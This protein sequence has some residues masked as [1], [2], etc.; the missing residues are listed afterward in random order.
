METGSYKPR[1]VPVDILRLL[2]QIRGETREMVASKN[3]DIEISL[4]DRPVNESD[5]F[6]I[7]GEEM[8]C[9]S[10][11]ANLLK[12]A[13]EASPKDE[14]ILLKLKTL[15]PPV[16]EINNQ[17]VIPGEIRETFFEKYSSSGKETG[18][19]LGTY[20]AKL[21]TLTLGGDIGFESD[22]KQGTTITIS[23]PGAAKAPVVKAEKPAEK[24]PTTE[25]SKNLNILVVDDSQNMRMMIITILKH[26]GFDNITQA[27]DGGDAMMMLGSNE[28][29]LIISDWDMPGVTGFELLKHVRASPDLKEIPFIMLTGVIGQDAIN[30]ANKENVNAYILKPF[31]ADIL[32]N[33]IEGIFE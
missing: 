14:R 29:E 11:L 23:L 2:N 19:G 6:Q 7:L 26:M 5:V 20:S 4:D 33:K 30:K 13:V 8:L 9:Y 16:I 31:S 25:I 32:Q 28:F 1:P 3:L 18:T 27:E 22:E 12:N 21:V 10:L 15:D 17:G 24:T